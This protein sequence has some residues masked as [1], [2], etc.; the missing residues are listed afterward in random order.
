MAMARTMLAMQTLKICVRGVLTDAR[1][2]EKRH[3]AC[4]VSARAL[5]EM[6]ATYKPPSE[7]MP[8]RWSDP[9]LLFS[10]TY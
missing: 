8:P 9:C 10:S 7:N 3:V 4:I 5:N 1:R 6:H 2:I